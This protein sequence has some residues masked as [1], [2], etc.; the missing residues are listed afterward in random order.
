MLEKEGGRK[1]VGVSNLG[2]SKLWGDKGAVGE[3]WGLL[4]LVSRLYH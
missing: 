1:G 3:K 2:N 4:L